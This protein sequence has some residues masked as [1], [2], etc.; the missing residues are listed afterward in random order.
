MWR[1]RVT[2]KS[3]AGHCWLNCCASG[4]W[5]PQPLPN[6][7]ATTGRFMPE[8]PAEDASCTS[9][10]CRDRCQQLGDCADCCGVLWGRANFWWCFV[11]FEGWPERI[12]LH[13]DR[14]LYAAMICYGLF[15]FVFS[16]C[17]RSGAF[18][19]H[20][21]LGLGAGCVILGFKVYAHTAKNVPNSSLQHVAA[22]SGL[23]RSIAQTCRFRRVWRH[24]WRAGSS[25]W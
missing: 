15:V 5:S 16:M 21:Y 19:S 10:P 8:P 6:K 20:R 13:Q 4:V 14:S 18:S 17:P 7:W 11:I 1:P 23:S 9:Q 12:I 25:C 24:G 22:L 3:T 2:N